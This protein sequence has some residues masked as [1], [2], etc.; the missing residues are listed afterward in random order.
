MAVPGIFE[1]LIL[2]LLIGVPVL[3]ITAGIA[4]FVVYRKKD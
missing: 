2:A 3:A 1:I 4:I